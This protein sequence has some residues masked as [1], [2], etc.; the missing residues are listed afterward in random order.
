MQNWGPA[1]AGGLLDEYVSG[2]WDVVVVDEIGLITC[3]RVVLG[4]KCP[5]HS[6]KRTMYF[7][8]NPTYMEDEN[9]ENQNED[10]RRWR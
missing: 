3:E 5:T 8:P 2:L 7:S 1:V 6:R 10:E 4:Q 9:Q